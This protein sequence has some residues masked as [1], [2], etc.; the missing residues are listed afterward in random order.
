MIQHFADNGTQIGSVSA[1]AAADAA[2]GQ[3]INVV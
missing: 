2:T 1:A 3:L